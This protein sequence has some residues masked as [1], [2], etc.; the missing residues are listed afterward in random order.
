MLT[1]NWQYLDAENKVDSETI[2]EISTI[3]VTKYDETR[4]P[5]R[6]EVITIGW[7]SIAVVPHA[8]LDQRIYVMNDSGKTVSTYDVPSRPAANED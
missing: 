4:R 7:G 2:Y 1:I 8:S 3:R 6:I 5:S